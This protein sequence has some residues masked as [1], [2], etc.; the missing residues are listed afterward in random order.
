MAKGRGKLPDRMPVRVMLSRW[1]AKT[2][3]WTPDQVA[4]LP[5]EEYEW[6]P[7]IEMAE[8]EAMIAEQ[9]QEQARSRRGRGR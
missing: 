2:Y 9:N 8:S 1:Y 4:E 7:V 5:I 3:G 6:L